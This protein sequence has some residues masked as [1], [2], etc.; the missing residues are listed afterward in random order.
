[1]ANVGGLV[2][3]ACVSSLPRVSPWDIPRVGR[4]GTERGEGGSGVSGK[5]L[6]V[7]TP[8]RKFRRSREAEKSKTI[9]PRPVDY[10][11]G[12]RVQRKTEKG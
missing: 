4:K 1:M 11:P 6:G 7:K 5:K 2:A 9:S 12:L 8:S 10:V 3:R